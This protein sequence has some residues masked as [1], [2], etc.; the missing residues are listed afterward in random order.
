MYTQACPG[1][2]LLVLTVERLVLTT[3]Y[4]AAQ[5]GSCLAL[6]RSSREPVSPA[7][8]QSCASS[9]VLLVPPPRSHERSNASPQRYA[10][11]K[12]SALFRLLRLL[13]PANCCIAPLTELSQ[14]R[15]VLTVL[16]FLRYKE[17]PY[18][19]VVETLM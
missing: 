7:R 9:P 13:A 12:E 17:N 5:T 10:R 18:A 14:C 15:S 16:T 6:P 3:S 11:I 2:R 1:S 4:V 8:S 19:V